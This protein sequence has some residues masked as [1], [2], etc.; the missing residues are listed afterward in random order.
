[1]RLENKTLEIKILRKENKREGVIRNEP[2][3]ETRLL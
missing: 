3:S 1:M 2:K